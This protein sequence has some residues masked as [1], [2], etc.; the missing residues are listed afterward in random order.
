MLRLNHPRLPRLVI[1][2]LIGVPIP[3]SVF[4]LAAVFVAAIVVL[5]AVM[6][7]M[8]VMVAVV[9]RFYIQH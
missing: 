9:I 4:V 8:V 6:A 2:L 7:V 5:A 1:R 3:P